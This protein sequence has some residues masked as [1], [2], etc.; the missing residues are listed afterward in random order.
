LISATHYEKG[1]EPSASRGDYSFVML[2]KARGKRVTNHLLAGDFVVKPIEFGAPTQ[3]EI[4]AVADLNGDGKME[5]VLFG[6]YYEGDFASVFEI[7]N[8]R[9][10]EIKEFRIACGL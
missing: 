5:I 4:S 2:R 9:P 8:G 3:N 1:V 10:V 6:F 7:K